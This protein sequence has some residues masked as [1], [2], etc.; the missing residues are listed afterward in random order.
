M[1]SGREETCRTE[2]SEVAKTSRPPLRDRDP[3]PMWKLF[4]IALPQ[5]GLQVLWSFLGPNS[6]PYMKHLGMG[7]ALATLNNIAAPVTGFFTGP[8]VGAM[9][10]NCTSRLGRRRPVILFGL[11]SFLV[12]GLLFAGVE[13]VLGEN[14]VYI[15]APMYWCLDITINI[16]QTPHR[17]LAADL[18]SEEQ[19]VPTQVMFVLISAIGNFLGFSI[20]HIYDIPVDHMLE[21]FIGIFLLNAVLVGIQFVVAQEIPLE[22][23]PAARR[24]SACSPIADTVTAVRHSPCLLYHLAVIQALVWIALTAWNA[25][26]GQWFANSVYQGDQN[27]PEGSFR[28]E[29]YAAGISAFALGGQMKAVAQLVSTMA[30]IAVML[31]KSFRP[32]LLYATCIFLGAVASFLAAFLV[33]HDG[34]FAEFCMTLSVM[35]ETGSFAIPYGLIA[36]VNHRMEKEGKF[37][38]TA[39]QMALLNCCIAVGQQ[40]C[41]LSL[42]GVEAGLPLQEEAL[43]TIFM[44][45]GGALV[46]AGVITLFLSDQRFDDDSSSESES[47]AE[48]NG[49][50]SDD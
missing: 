10:D 35:P 45:A 30:I 28:R 40:I 48:E 43:P 6:A 19:Q 49:Q 39:L 2:Y 21:L 8:I 22:G 23:E 37:V 5:L 27:A 46:L 32:R 11:V 25:Y 1:E 7:S 42:S 9:S 17:A 16:M 18:A 31:R 50:S 20:M 24:K 47:E 12:A 38:S 36:L 41:T 15:A 34:V 33:D 13:H 26:A 3:W 4:L 14:A 44:L 29:A